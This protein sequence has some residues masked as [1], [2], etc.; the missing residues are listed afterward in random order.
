L[1]LYHSSDIRFSTSS[2]TRLVL[3]RLGLVLVR[4]GLVLVRLEM[5]LPR[6]PGV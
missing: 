3:V 4:L 1:S 6:A 5:W 2:E